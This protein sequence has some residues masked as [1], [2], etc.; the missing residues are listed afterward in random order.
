M[1]WSQLVYSCLM[2]TL[3][4][5]CVSPS[6][7]L[8]GPQ[9]DVKRCAANGWGFVG[10]PLAEHS[11]HNC[12]DDLKGIGYVPIEEVG[13][14]GIQLSQADPQMVTVSVVAANSPAGRAGISVG[15]Q[16]VKINGQQVLD[17]AAANTMMFG[18]AGDSVTLTIRRGGS[19]N[20]YQLLRAS[21]P[22]SS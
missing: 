13:T 17:R 14:L 9:G 3:V 16:I 4:A 1:R 19:E 21:R 15:D 22:I 7:M 2:A 18:K 20:V 8:V 12:T 5:G 6:Q 11:V 10:A